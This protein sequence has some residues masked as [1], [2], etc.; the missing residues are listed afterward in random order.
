MCAEAVKWARQQ[1]AGG[2]TEKAVLLVL[3]AESDRSGMCHLSTRRIAVEADIGQTTVRG[4]L[5]RLRKRGL[6][7]WSSGAG[8]ATNTY[9]LRLP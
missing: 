9:R 8:R 1:R 6:V 5:D 4:S 3:A 2:P 7:S